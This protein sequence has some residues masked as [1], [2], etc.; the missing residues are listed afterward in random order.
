MYI[1]DW[2]KLS[3]IIE[4][5]YIETKFYVPL[6]SFRNFRSALVVQLSSKSGRRKGFRA[7]QILRNFSTCLRDSLNSVFLST[8]RIL[9]LTYRP[10]CSPRA[11]FLQLKSTPSSGSLPERLSLISSY[12]WYFETLAVVVRWMHWFGSEKRWTRETKHLLFAFWVWLTVDHFL[13]T[14]LPEQ[15]ERDNN[16]RMVVIFWNIVTRSEFASEYHL[17]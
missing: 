4:Y 11:L 14:E 6:S 17:I 9:R 10:Y 8:R 15:R 7:L 16:V 3:V 2:I 1:E 13:V 5:S 12:C